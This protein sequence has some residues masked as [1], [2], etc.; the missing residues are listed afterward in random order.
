MY[1]STLM[2][3]KHTRSTTNKENMAPV[4]DMATPNDSTEQLAQNRNVSS[5]DLGGCGVA[6]N[7]AQGE[8]EEVGPPTDEVVSEI[9]A[10]REQLQQ[11]LDDKAELIEESILDKER[12]RDQRETIELLT[13]RIREFEMSRSSSSLSLVPPAR[14][15]SSTNL[16]KQLGEDNIQMAKE[17]D[18]LIADRDRLERKLIDLKIKYANGFL[19]TRQNSGA[20]TDEEDLENNVFS[21]LS[22]DEKLRR[23]GKPLGGNKSL[24]R[25]WFRKPS[26]K[27]GKPNEVTRARSNSI[28]V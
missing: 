27:S 21:T 2:T 3:R 14:T 4:V 9:E 23:K 6:Y 24:F 15:R 28:A 19:V 11:A 16:L 10:L 8:L 22:I 17:M 5:C 18:R 7:Q 13:K 26:K 1:S 25:N 12:I 20:S